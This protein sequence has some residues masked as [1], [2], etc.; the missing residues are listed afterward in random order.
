MEIINLV[1]AGNNLEP[2]I[3]QEIA[4]LDGVNVRLYRLSCE[5]NMQD[6]EEHRD[7]EELVIV[8]DGELTLE[9]PSKK[10]SLVSG[11]SILV[12]PGTPHRLTTPSEA[13]CIIMRNMSKAPLSKAD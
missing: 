6:F 9:V 10:S 2:L 5:N 12:S 4:S 3:G 8:L 1:K 7:V 13:I 11:D